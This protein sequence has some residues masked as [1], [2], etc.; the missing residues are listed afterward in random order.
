MAQHRNGGG[1][2][3]P[4]TIERKK[5]EKAERAQRRK[6]ARTLRAAAIVAVIVLAGGGVLFA[7]NARSD[8]LHDLSAIGRGVPA[9]VQVHDVTCPIC[10]QLRAN[11]RGIEG[12]FGDDEL[13]IRVADVADENGLA[14]AARY[15]DQR[16]VTLLYFDAT[17]RLTDVQSGLQTEDELRRSF[18]AHIGGE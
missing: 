14:F 18:R 8:Q 2:G 12:E 5:A 6:R 17:G 7:V 9:V 11:I 10:T 4:Q 16:R 15:T 1:S 3:S 13:V